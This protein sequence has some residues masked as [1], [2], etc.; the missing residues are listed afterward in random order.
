M[1]VNKDHLTNHVPVTRRQKKLV[2]VLR[3]PIHTY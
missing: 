1:G 3:V 2:I